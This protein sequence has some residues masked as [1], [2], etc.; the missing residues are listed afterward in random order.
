MRVLILFFVFLAFAACTPDKQ[1]ELR[2]ISLEGICSQRPG[3]YPCN[4]TLRDQDDKDIALY[5]FYGEITI[6]DISAM[7][8]GPCVMAAG[9]VQEIA[10]KYSI[11]YVTLLIEDTYGN[12]PDLADVRAWSTNNKIKEPV[13]QGSTDMISSWPDAGWPLYALPTFYVM[14]EEL[15]I[16]VVQSGYNRSIMESYIEV[17]QE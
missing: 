12:E 14:D 16:Q 1:D 8:C 15:V 3:Y 9:D 13:L 11:N 17:L 4:F 10:D 2:P 6:L 7:W 5:S